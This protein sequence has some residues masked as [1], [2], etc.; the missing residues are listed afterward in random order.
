[1]NR[2]KV[3]SQVLHIAIRA[4]GGNQVGMGHIM[5]CLSLANVFRQKGHRVFFISK[6]DEGI[7]RIGREQFDVIRLLSVE[8]ETEGFGYGNAGGS[9]EM[10]KMIDILSAYEVDILIIDSY[11]VNEEDFN[12]LKPQVRRLI[13][14]DDINAFS[15]PA[16]FIVNGNITGEYLEY[17]KDNDQQV[18]LLGPRYN[19]IRFEFSHL[20]VRIVNEQV[21]E[22]MVT[23]G[24][25]DPYHITARLLKVM[26]QHEE[27]RNFR[28][29]VLVGSGFDNINELINLQHSHENVFLFA[30]SAVIHKFPEIIYSEISPLM[31]RSD[32]AISAGGSSLYEFSACGTPVMAFIMADNQE[33]IVQKMAELGYAKSLGWY[34]RL[35]DDVIMD[36]L[37]T[38]IN[39]VQQR[40]DMSSKGQSLVDG[41][42]T[43]RI[44]NRIIQS[45][46]AKE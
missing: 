13:Y 10:H 15:Y 4:D 1:M 31:L 34:N 28:F 36:G 30:N 20:P 8:K 7:E 21:Q 5:R 44:V 46:E 9:A 41:K 43:E 6:L 3:K 18:L 22:V 26:L 39:A 45:L 12:I 16:D 14:I 37:L 24:G 38:L 40:R 32:L 19:M 33:F 11:H 25:S 42:G 35:T 23:T 2:N 29:N 17:R 27:C